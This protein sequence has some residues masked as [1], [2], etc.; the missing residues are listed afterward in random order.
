MSQKQ[1]LQWALQRP[2]KLFLIDGLGACLSAFLLGVVLVE[3]ESL[4]GIPLG[5]LYFLALLPCLFILFDV[6]CYRTN[7]QNTAKHLLAIAFMNIGYCVLSLG[8]MVY[9]SDSM[10]SFGFGYIIL[11]VIVV[12]GIAAFEIKVAKGLGF[13]N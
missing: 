6:Y 11:E 3:F 2:K 13:D 4:F 7:S 10:T 12:L 8:F 5:T 9:H 1:T